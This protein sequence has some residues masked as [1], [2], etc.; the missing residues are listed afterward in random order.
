MS[1]PLSH[2]ASTATIQFAP[3]RDRTRHAAPQVFELLREKIITL[4]LPPGSVLSRQELQQQF[5]LSSTPI[6]DALMRL[7]EEALVEIFPQ[8]ATKVSRID[9]DH[10]RQAA[11]L[12]R[13][14]EV[15]VAHKLAEQPDPALIERL[16]QTQRA[17][18][19]FGEAGDLAQFNAQDRLLHRLMYDAVGVPDLWHLVQRRNGHI[20][21]LRR[22]HLP[23]P[24]KLEQTLRDHAAIIDA[25]AAGDTEAASREVRLHLSRSL[26]FLPAIRA[27]YPGYFRD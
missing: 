14:I 11:F 23:M 16:R 10:A 22:L 7:E 6:R 20:D 2:D 24:G 13:A 1:S 27:Q 8:H 18:Q 9:L 3:I 4:E 26:A 17:Q 19:A 5:G 12:R 21:R 25:I 15:E